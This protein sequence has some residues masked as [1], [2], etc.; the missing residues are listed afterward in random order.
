[1]KTQKRIELW[2][3]DGYFRKVHH[4]V[5][6]KDHQAQIKSIDWKIKILRMF[7]EQNKE[8]KDA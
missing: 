8:S 1:M 7:L 5:R 4:L 6:I 3:E 2:I